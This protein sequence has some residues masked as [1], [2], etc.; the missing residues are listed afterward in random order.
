VWYCPEFV[1]DGSDVYLYGLYLPAGAIADVLGFNPH[2]DLVQFVIVMTVVFVSLFYVIVCLFAWLYGLVDRRVRRIA[3][4]KNPERLL[5][6]IFT[7]LLMFEL[8][9]TQ[10]HFDD[11]PWERDCGSSFEYTLEKVDYGS[12]RVVYRNYSDEQ[13]DAADLACNTA[14]HRATTLGIKRI[15]PYFSML[16]CLCAANVSSENIEEYVRVHDLRNSSIYPYAFF[17]TNDS[18]E[19]YYAILV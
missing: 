4:L 19:V 7:F 1:L 3:P 10:V 9:F 5:V 6:G 12:C 13:F 15:V 2:V 8:V 16:K 11:T 14:S 18:C 17:N